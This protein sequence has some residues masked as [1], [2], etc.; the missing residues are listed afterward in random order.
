[1]FF[2]FFRGLSRYS[3]LN[4]LIEALCRLL[5]RHISP[6]CCIVY[7]LDVYY[8]NINNKKHIKSKYTL[9]LASTC[10]EDRKTVKNISLCPFYV[11]C[12]FYSCFV[13]LLLWPSRFSLSLCLSLRVCISLFCFLQPAI[14]SIW[15]W[16]FPF[17]FVRACI[18]LSARII[19]GLYIG[20]NFVLRLILFSFTYIF[21]SF[22]GL[23]CVIL[24]TYN[25]LGR[26]NEQCAKR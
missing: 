24:I 9:A 3:R 20:A 11:F 25:S 22:H 2:S 7:V 8:A 16:S 14:A 5:Y 26:M 13:F 12:R 4:V 23:Y 17:V 1:M 19:F 15:P 18:A 10:M 6:V 21:D